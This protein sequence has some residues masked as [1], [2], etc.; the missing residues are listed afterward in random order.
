[1][2]GFGFIEY[3]D[4]MD[5]RDVV[6]GKASSPHA[7][8]LSDITDNVAAFRTISP[9]QKYCQLHSHDQ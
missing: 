4:S 3:K 7:G 8:G 2:N 1:M 9:L 6:P 5:A